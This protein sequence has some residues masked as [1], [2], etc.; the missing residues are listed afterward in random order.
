MAYAYARRCRRNAILE[1]FGDRP[2][3]GCTRCDVCQGSS[4]PQMAPDHRQEDPCH[5]ALFETLRGLR[6]RK[7]RELDVPAYK[8]FADATL[9]EMAAML[10]ASYDELLA[11][12]GV[13]KEKLARH[14]DE[15]LGAI[16]AFR[17]LNPELV[18]AKRPR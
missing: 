14:G 9:K 10:P 6:G 5:P 12:R 7:A 18:K 15:F 16:V 17:E 13:G 2:K 1:Y 4:D 3:G 11:I 8:V